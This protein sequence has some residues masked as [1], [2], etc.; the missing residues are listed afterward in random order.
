M[1]AGGKHRNQAL[2]ELLQGTRITLAYPD[3]YLAGLVDKLVHAN[4]AHLPVVSRTDGALVGYI[5]W[6]DLMRVRQR[7]AT[8]THER[9]GIDEAKTQA[10]GP[11]LACGEFCNQQLSGL[12]WPQEA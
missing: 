8:E 3:E 4:V 10:R 2:G 12:R 5:G 1:A 6:K 9:V 11:A 7:L